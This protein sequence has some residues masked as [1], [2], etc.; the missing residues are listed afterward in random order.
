M[1]EQTTPDDDGVRE[2]EGTC[3]TCDGDARIFLSPD[4]EERGHIYCTEDGCGWI[5]RGQS[6]SGYI[7][8]EPSAEVHHLVS[9]TRGELFQ[10]RAGLNA[11][12]GRG[13]RGFSQVQSARDKAA[14]AL[15]DE[16]PSAELRVA[17]QSAVASWM[18]EH[19][20]RFVCPSIEHWPEGIDDRETAV[21]HYSRQATEEILD[22]L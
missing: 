1:V 18:G 12:E 17:L 19:G 21:E 13:P 16:D 20:H 8:E 9:F 7:D 15:E 3:P 14:V 2:V 10:I 5:H 4:D 6:V 11:P 22:S